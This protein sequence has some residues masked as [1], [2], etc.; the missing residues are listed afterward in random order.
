[1]TDYALLVLPAANAVYAD[2]APWLTRVE[3]GVFNTA[4]LDGRLTDIAE[5]TL[6]GVPYVRFSADALSPDDIALIS[7][8]S[9]LYA[10]FELDGGALRPLDIK[11]LDRLPGDLITI[12]RY[13]GKTNPY[14]TKLLLNVT[15]LARGRPREMTSQR[16]TVLDP[17]CG[18]G[19]TLNQALMYGYDAAGMEIDAKDFDAYRSFFGTWLKDHRFKHELD[20]G[21]VRRDRKTIGRRLHVAFAGTKQAYKS[22]ETQTLEVINAD[23]ARLPDFFKSATFDA[24]VADLPYGVLHESR[25]QTGDAARRPLEMLAESL[26][27]WVAALRPGGAIGMAWNT[28]V[29]SRE[30]IVEAL[31][32]DDLELVDHGPNNPFRHTVDQSITRDLI[33]AR[34]R[35]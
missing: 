26:P 12:Q 20:A 32:R 25:G 27:G 22:G 9:S 4:A 5:A 35:G 3:L 11:P 2:A 13:K 15:L 33:V 16:L 23:S 1:M 30:R 28:K 17:L 18:R 21:E 8:L 7:N 14:F 34:K 31:T 10:L 24:V 29:A 19:T 6:G